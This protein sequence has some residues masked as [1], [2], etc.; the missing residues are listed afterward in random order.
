MKFISYIYQGKP[1]YGI[2]NQNS[3]IVPLATI[4]SS[5]NYDVPP[6]LLAFIIEYGRTIN[7]EI[8]SVLYHFA[9]QAISLTEVKLLS[10][11]RYPRRNV[12]CVGKNYQDHALEVTEFTNEGSIQL[13]TYPIYFSKA[14]DVLLGDQE[15]IEI[16]QPSARKLDYEVELAVIIA[17]DGKDIDLNATEQYIFGYAVSNDI[18]ARDLQTARGQWFKGKSLD[19]SLALGPYLVSA[20]EIAFPPQLNISAKVNG[21]LRQKSNTA[22]FIFDLATLISDLS[23]GMTLRAGDIIMTGTPAGVGVAMKPPQYLKSGDLIEFE[24]ENIGKLTNSVK[25]VD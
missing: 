16:R 21:E 8:N 12:F 24:I 3:Q 10:P 1:D 7:L 11:I 20:E 23:Q 17:K 25:I 4:L 2:L 19:N 14:C 15:I 18:S 13:P 22:N 5:L 6:D 9:D